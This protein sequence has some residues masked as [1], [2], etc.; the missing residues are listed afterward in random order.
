MKGALIIESFD[1]KTIIGCG[2][3]IIAIIIGVMHLYKR[4]QYCVEQLD[5]DNSQ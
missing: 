2:F 4:R 5:E 3:Y 1:I